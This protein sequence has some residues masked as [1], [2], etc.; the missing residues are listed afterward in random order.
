MHGIIILGA[1]GLAKEFA[2]YV[3]RAG[4]FDSL[5]FVNDLQDGQTTLTI[6][7]ESFPVVK[8]WSFAHKHPFVVAVGS[9]G[10]KQLLVER[11]LHA[12][13]DPHPTILDPAA[14]NLCGAKRLGVGGVVA[15][16]CVITTNVTLG[17]Y[18]TLNLNSTVGHDT[19]MGS[20]CTTNPGVHISGECV[21]GSHNEFGTGCIVR[22]R[23]TIGS[24]KTFGAQ[25]AV[26]KDVPGDQPE[27][28]VGVPAK[29][30][31]RR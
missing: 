23:L 7:R 28:L 20:F 14:H 11:A 5:T 26:V 15:P 24:R 18:V 31:T 6:G 13:L 29:P 22:D 30:L 25:S 12:G 2:L 8:D 21:I 17:D 19:T 1:A 16:G 27:V 4:G 9:P 3:R 10:I